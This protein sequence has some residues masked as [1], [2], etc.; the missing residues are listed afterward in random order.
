MTPSEIV[1][2]IIPPTID[3]ALITAMLIGIAAWLIGIALFFLLLYAVIVT[4]IKRGM[5]DHQ[6][7]LEGRDRVRTVTAPQ[8]L[9]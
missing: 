8:N 6:L 9:R 1:N 3:Q 4:A 5:R 7:W 2:P